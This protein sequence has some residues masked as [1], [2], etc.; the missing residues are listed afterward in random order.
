[1]SGR[2]KAF[3]T[4]SPTGSTGG[5][6]G[7][8]S[9]YDATRDGGHTTVRT[10]LIS[11]CA[12]A[13]LAVGVGGCGG[14]D[15]ASVATTATTAS[16]TESTMATTSTTA[17]HTGTAHLRVVVAGGTATGDTEPTVA[18]GS[19]V[20]MHVTADDADTVHVHGY[21]KEFQIKAGKEAMIVFTADIPGRFEVELHHAGT[22]V[23]EL[24]V[25]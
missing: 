1:M 6:H 18:L 14:T 16:L 10:K 5:T 11:I 7:K 24:T 19:T 22:K 4:A 2:S 20:M 8:S 13:A 21:D 9:H 25:K 12:L 23:M 3:T 15:T 17:A